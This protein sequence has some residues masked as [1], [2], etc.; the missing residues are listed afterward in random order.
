MLMKI[1]GDHVAL[2][3]D[4]F[5]KEQGLAAR[6]RA[7]VEY[8]MAGIGSHKARYGLGTLI[9]DRYPAA[10]HRFAR[11]GVSRFKNPGIA[12]QLSRQ[13]AAPGPLARPRGI[14]AALWVEQIA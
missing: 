3:S 5:C 1:R 8:G 12:E 14:L 7:Q 4:R 13:D 11:R 10:T 6:G 2:S 9:L